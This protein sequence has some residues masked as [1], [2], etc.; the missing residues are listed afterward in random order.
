MIKYK[1]IAIE[2]STI[3]SILLV[4]GLIFI[5]L[6]QQN[7]FTAIQKVAGQSNINIVPLKTEAFANV[8][9]T[10]IH[11]TP[12]QVAIETPIANSTATPSSMPKAKIASSPKPVA[13]KPAAKTTITAA[14]CAGSFNQQFLCLLNQYRATKNLKAVASNSGL[15]KAALTHSSWMN[16]TS[17]FSHTGLN[18]SR[19]T[20]RCKSAGITCRAENLAKGSKSA[21]NLLDMWK[22]SSEHNA[23]LLGSYS[24]AGLGVS[25]AYTSLLMN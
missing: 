5:G 25:G 14:S 22:S 15:A 24:T 6:S 13:L 21:Q 1:R 19:L 12:P 10:D 4:G 3:S 2:I 9:A 18:G 7:S 23:I 11:V 16:S 17:T 8:T 20:D